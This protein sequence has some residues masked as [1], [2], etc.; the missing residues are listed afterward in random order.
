MDT[1]DADQ[2]DAVAELGIVALAVPTMMTDIEAA[3]ELARES[4][5]AGS[6]VART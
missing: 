1:T 2:V 3:A 6:T 4:L 5:A